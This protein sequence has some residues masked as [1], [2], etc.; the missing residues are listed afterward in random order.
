[1]FSALKKIVFWNYRRTAWQYDVLCLLIL[2]F[3]FLTPKTWFDGGELR[4][5]A[6]HQNSVSPAVVLPVSEGGDALSGESDMSEIE[7]RARAVSNRPDAQVEA[8]RARRDASG[9]I[10]AY[11]VD[12][13]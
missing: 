2:A 13:R 12:I 9:Q 7:R 3:V 10:V 6:E 5:K 11:E 8:V 4:N 1:M